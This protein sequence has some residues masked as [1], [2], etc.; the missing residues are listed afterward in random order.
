VLDDVIMGGA[1]AS[2]IQWSGPE[3]ALVFSGTVTT[4]FNG[5]FA[6]VRSLPW[7]GWAALG[8][9]RGVRLLVRG[10]PRP[11]TYKL[12]LKTDD[13]WDGV[14]WQADFT[15]PAADGGGGGGAAEAWATI[16]IPFS[17][18]LPSVRGRVVPAPPLE[19]ARVRQLGFML[20]KVRAAGWGRGERAWRGWAW[21]A[22]RRT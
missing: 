19:P 2:T 6:S 1:S 18:F 14:A 13:S 5:G 12:N 10:G 22:M 3:R 11:V 16:H 7:A 8:R 17:S 9:G 21:G 15:V 4:A 20:S